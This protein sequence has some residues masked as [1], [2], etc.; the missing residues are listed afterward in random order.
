MENIEHIFQLA[1]LIF[2]VMEIV[3]SFPLENFL[4]LK[5]GDCC[6]SEKYSN[7]K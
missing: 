2:P 4:L 1:L 7:F 3:K 6:E 5:T